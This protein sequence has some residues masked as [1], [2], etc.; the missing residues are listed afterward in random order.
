GFDCVTY[1]ETVLALSISRSVEEFLMN[2][3]ELRYDDGKVEWAK[4][5]H[6][7][8]DWAAHHIRH[9]FLRDMTLG[10]E[11]V[12]IEKTL[13]FIEGLRPKRVRIRYYPKIQYS[14]VSRW[15]TDGDILYFLSMRRDL[16]TFH[17]GAVFRDGD[18]LSIRHARHMRHRVLEQPLA[19]FVR[20]IKSPG[21]IV[22]RVV[23]N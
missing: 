9:N 18:Q 12:V 21:F 23:K 14:A 11:T 10:D 16:D 7:T 5:L 22:N 4:R 8:T 15:L 2:L 17:M 13:S 6:Y 1:V 19:E 20:A 3:R